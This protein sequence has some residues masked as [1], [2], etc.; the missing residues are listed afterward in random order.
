MGRQGVT[1][2]YG[3]G[4]IAGNRSADI[5]HK[6]VEGSR[7]ACRYGNRIYCDVLR[8]ARISSF[9]DRQRYDVDTYVT[10]FCRGDSLQHT[11]ALVFQATIPDVRQSS[12]GGR[13]HGRRDGLACTVQCTDHVCRTAVVSY[14]SCHTDALYRYCY[15][16]E[17]DAYLPDCRNRDACRPQLRQRPPTRPQDTGSRRRMARPP[18]GSIWQC[19]IESRE[20]DMGHIHCFYRLYDLSVYQDRDGIRYRKFDGT[21]RAL[22]K[23]YT[24]SE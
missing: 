8:Y 17:R 23:R 2:Y 1:S 7:S 3:A 18:S 9:L 15:F 22:C 12:A 19:G 5:C 4:Y 16:Y 21:S 24:R 11:R 6:V 13:R 14:H 20:S 10:G